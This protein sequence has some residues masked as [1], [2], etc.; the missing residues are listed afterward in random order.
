LMAVIVGGL[1]LAGTLHFC[2]VKASTD[3]TGIIQASTELE[4]IPKPSVPEFTVELVDSSYDVPT[5]YSTDPYTG[6]NVT[7]AGYHV[8][9]RTIEV[10]IKNQPFVSYYDAGRGWTINFY[11]NIRLKG[12]FSEDWKELFRASDGYLTQSDSEYTVISYQ[13]EYS[14][15]EG[16]DF[17]SQTIM[18]NF[19]SGSQLDFQVEAMIGYVHRDASIPFAPWVFTGEKSGWSETLTLTVPISTQFPT[20]T[21]SPTTT[22]EPTPPISPTPTPNENS[23]TLQSEAIVGA[24]I[25]VAV[26]VA[27]LGLL[28]Y[29]IKR[30]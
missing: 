17:T 2:M 29:L 7:H 20:I 19:P 16:M 14:P 11:Y 21:L 15:T 3:V 23:R 1:L 24:F 28:I 22:P 26:I 6:E 12:H 18:T 13:G 9:S 30:R 5:T 8:E 27:G 10:K 25:A 4:P